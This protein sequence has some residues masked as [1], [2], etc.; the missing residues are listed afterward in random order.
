M[1]Y[2][3]LFY[4]VSQMKHG[5]CT[6]RSHL[7][8]VLLVSLL[9]AL[10]TVPIVLAQP[11]TTAE[12]TEAGGRVTDALSVASFAPPKGWVAWDFWGTMAFSPTTGHEPRLTFTVS[13]RDG[14][15]TRDIESVMKS[16]CATFTTEN[17]TLITK[18][19]LSTGGYPGVRVLAQG[20]DKNKVFG[21]DYVWVQEYLTSA[22]RITLTLLSDKDSFK[23]CE[24]G[25]LDSFRSLIVIERAPYGHQ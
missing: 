6:A 1:I 17:Y 23:G 13:A 19:Y 5:S 4:R 14:R 8:L 24:K 3:A 20:T 12:G 9:I 22:H 10:Y 16:L 2:C 7:A 18:E 15:Y 25:V 11:V 21:H